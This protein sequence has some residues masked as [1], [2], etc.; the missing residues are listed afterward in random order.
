ME[1][2]AQALLARKQALDR[3]DGIQRELE[4]GWHELRARLVSGCTASD[5]A[6]AHVYLRS[7]EKRRDESALN[8]E[9]AERRV[10]AAMQSMLLARQQR[11]VVDACF[12][13]QKER[14]SRD[15]VRQDQKVLDDLASRRIPS[16]LS[17][18]QAEPSP[19]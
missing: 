6:R 9:V 16:I 4:K 15:A 5:A 11:E 14:H 18:T 17:W 1:G 7:L 8:L 19:L 3:L 10:N 12:D 13:K 2:Y